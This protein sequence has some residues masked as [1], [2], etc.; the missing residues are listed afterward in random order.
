MTLKVW[1]EPGVVGGIEQP[2]GRVYVE[3]PVKATERG[4]WRLLINPDD[5]PRLPCPHGRYEPHGGCCCTEFAG[6]P[7]GRYVDLGT[8]EYSGRE[9]RV[10]DHEPRCNPWLGEAVV[11]LGEVE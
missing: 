8:D 10:C 9:W 5:Q 7:K 1:Y 6:K 2:F 11:S 4:R 3:K